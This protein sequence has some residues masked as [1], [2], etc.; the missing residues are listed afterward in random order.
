MMAKGY[1]V[2]WIPENCNS[3]NFAIGDRCAV[4]GWK[5]WPFI[6]HHCK[7]DDCPIKEIPERMEPDEGDI[8]QE[9]YADGRNELID[10]MF[11]K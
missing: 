3:C 2:T 11:G 10:E 6:G 8:E 4:N 9:N 1:V 7:P 5:I